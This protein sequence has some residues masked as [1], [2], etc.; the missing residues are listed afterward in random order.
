MPDWYN[1]TR[2]CWIDFA[3][4]FTYEITELKKYFKSVRGKVLKIKICQK[5]AQLKKQN[6][7]ENAKNYSLKYFFCW[8]KDSKS[9]KREMNVLCILKGLWLISLN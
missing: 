4:I 8:F 2:E 9:L 7:F 3:N 1:I 6:K 5:L